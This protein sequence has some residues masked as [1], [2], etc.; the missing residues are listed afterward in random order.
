M[1]AVESN[2]LKERDADCVAN[3]CICHAGENSR[4]IFRTPRTRPSCVVIGCSNCARK[5]ERCVRNGMMPDQRTSDSTSPDSTVSNHRPGEN[6]ED[7]SSPESGR[8][9]DLP[10][11]RS[12]D[13][14]RHER[15][16]HVNPHVTM[17]VS[18]TW[19]VSAAQR[20]P[21]DSSSH[22]L[23]FG[24]LARC[25]HEKTFTASGAL[26]A[27]QALWGRPASDAGAPA[28]GR[29]AAA[30]VERAVRGAEG[31]AAE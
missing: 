16:S 9:A 13:D 11:G 20:M 2:M 15:R 27:A 21:A 10:A 19:N 25:R 23:R 4:P 24:S 12:R 5:I 1:P 18:A 22:A 31:A 29:P 28:P 6:R 30:L 14:V 26:A 8:E 17:S 7:P 3:F